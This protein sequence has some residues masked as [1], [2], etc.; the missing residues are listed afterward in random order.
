MKL[1]LSY[2]ILRTV[3]VTI[4]IAV[5]SIVAGLYVA[6]SVPSVQNIIRGAPKKNLQICWERRLRSDVFR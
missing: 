6:L 2:K 1:R 5:A 3:L 4:I